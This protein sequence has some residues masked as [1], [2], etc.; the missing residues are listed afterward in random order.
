MEN[1]DDEEETAV[2][3]KSTPHESAEKREH[4]DQIRNKERLKKRK[5]R[6]MVSTQDRTGQD[7]KWKRPT[8]EIASTVAF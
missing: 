6:E 3:S 5:N 4:A 8:S 7:D 2:T 1:E